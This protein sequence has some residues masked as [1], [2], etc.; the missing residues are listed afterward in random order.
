MIYSQ[1]LTDLYEVNVVA[2]VCCR[3]LT[4]KDLPATYSP[5][6]CFPASICL[7]KKVAG[8]LYETLRVGFVEKSASLG[9]NFPSVGCQR[10]ADTGSKQQ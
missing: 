7:I 5:T 3:Y 9:L 1:A 10:G 4:A 8:T 2:A 6:R